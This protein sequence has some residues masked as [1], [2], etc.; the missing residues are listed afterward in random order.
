MSAADLLPCDGCAETAPPAPRVLLQ[1]LDGTYCQPCA[2]EIISDCVGGLEF[3][4]ELELPEA[5]TTAPVP[6]PHH[7]DY[8][9]FHLNCAEI[10]GA[11]RVGDVVWA[12]S[13]DS[14]N[15]WREM[16]EI[17]EVRGN[18]WFLASA[19]GGQGYRFK[20]ELRW[21]APSTVFYAARN[22]HEVE[23]AEG[24]R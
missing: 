22:V 9:T 24:S 12:P 11:A 16:V 10:D 5:A 4:A 21:W 18:G 6:T 8:M 14:F 13:A 2:V 7:G 20:A 3:L 1:H 19:V 17:V 23:L 15:P